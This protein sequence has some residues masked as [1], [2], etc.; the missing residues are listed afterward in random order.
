MILI[1]LG[2]YEEK[3]RESDHVEGSQWP[4]CHLLQDFYRGKEAMLLFLK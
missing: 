3:N 4:K 2:E 1:L